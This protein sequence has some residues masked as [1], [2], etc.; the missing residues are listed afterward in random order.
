MQLP[1]LLVIAPTLGANPNR[2]GG[3]AEAY[4]KALPYKPQS[5]LLVSLADKAHNAEAILFDYRE[6]GE[7][8]WDRR[9][10]G[11]N[12]VVLRSARHLL[13]S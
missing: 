9:R 6:H 8:L 4:L 1:T 7:A 5:S 11:G 10:S 2:S 12:P 13:R 3:R